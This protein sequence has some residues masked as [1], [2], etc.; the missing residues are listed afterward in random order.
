MLNNLYVFICEHK[1][2]LIL[3]YYYNIVHLN[4]QLY[5]YVYKHDKF[6][7][8]TRQNNKFIF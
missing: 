3:I 8:I 6:P 1:C 4:T 5:I 2:E 7:Y